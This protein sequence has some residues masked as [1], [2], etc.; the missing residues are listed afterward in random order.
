M[1]D[2]LDNEIKNQHVHMFWA[3]LITLI[4]NKFGFFW[5]WTGLCIGVVVE[6]YQLVIKREGLKISDRVLD[7]SFWFLGSI[8]AYFVR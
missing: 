6:L 5:V 7:L 1:N 2:K 3:L 8:I 4:L